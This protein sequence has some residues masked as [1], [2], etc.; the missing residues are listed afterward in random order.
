[1]TKSR[2]GSP[3][4]AGR[5]PDPPAV[6]FHLRPVVSAFAT[7]TA[8]LEGFDHVH[9]AVSESYRRMI[10]RDPIGHTFREIFAAPRNEEV[11]RLLDRVYETGKPGS[12]SAVPISLKE[13]TSGADAYFLDFVCNPVGEPSGSVAGVLIQVTDK[14]EEVWHERE[15]AFLSKASDVLASSL[16][17]SKTLS[18][19]ARLAVEGIADWCAVDELHPDGSIR[20]IAVAHPDPE[21]VEMAQAIGERYPPDPDAAHGIAH[22]LRTGESEMIPEIP[23]E[24]LAAVAQDEEHLRMIR[25]L[26]LRSYMAVPIV[27]RG[28][29]LGALALVRSDS[30]RPFGERA[31][32]L[33]EELAR[34]AAV[35]MD[36][37]RLFRDSEEARG[38]LQEQAK[39]LEESRSDLAATNRELAAQA[40][41]AEEARTEAVA[42]R[43]L[44]DAFFAGSAVAMGFYDRDLRHVRVN[45]A[46]A[47]MGG[48]SPEEL[49]GKTVGD[50]APDYAATVEPLL[51][52]VLET[53]QPLLNREITGPRPTDPTTTA[54]YLVSYFPVRVIADEA[55]GLG[56]VALDLTDLRNAEQRERIFSQ[57]LEES[58]NEIYLFDAESLRFVRVN[59]GARENLGYSMGELQALTPLDLKPEYT[60]EEFAE[61]IEPLRQGRHDMIHFET[62]HRRKDG[63]LYPVDVHL[64]LSRAAE[65]P[66]F[67]ALIVD[68]TERKDAEREVVEG[69]ERLRAVV[70]TAVDGIITIAERGNI[71]TVNPATEQIFGYTASE[72]IGRNVAMLMPEPYRSEHDGYLARYLATGERRIIGIGREV[73]GRRKDGTTFQLDLAISETTLEDRRF[74]TGIVRDVTERTRAAEELLAARDAAEQ[75]SQA[76]SKFLTVMSHELRT[77]LNAIIGFEDLLEAEVAGPLTD[78]QR[79][80]LVRIKAGATQLLDLI[81]QI[82]NLA[83]IES[84]MIDVERERV[85]LAKLTREAG[86]LVEALASKK[87]LAMQVS[88]PSSAIHVVTDPGKVRQILL[89]LLGNAVKFTEAGAVELSIAVRDGSVDISVIDTGP[90]ISEELQNRVFEPFFQADQSES[91]RH[92]G[93]GLGLAVSRELARLIGGELLVVSR[94]GE[95]SNFTLSIPAR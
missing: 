27:A 35:A 53:G 9:T 24:L 65:R 68:T 7:P 39:R 71:E 94:P 70:E 92:G 62:V 45:P 34:R 41:A 74:F 22:V 20:R 18:A 28:R 91:Q 25:E 80:H 52:Q 43:A 46:L 37:A 50:V 49:I 23:D 67:A 48:H 1:M 10:G 51:R 66:L 47:A 44:L 5:V 84:G 54:H 93:T 32:G 85:D 21:M 57:V 83:R 81:N 86:S 36:N 61:L 6:L 4:P 87:G 2:T 13:P 72:M 58:R 29:I 33:A 55:I 59:R 12:V 78:Q 95:G 17:Y 31:L 73:V 76:K 40:S 38:V 89:N 79:S 11:S 60:P 19:V 82:L 16:D 8:I 14:T 42:A 56:I 30:G 26:G 90:G 64:Q 88:V 75:A 77:P 3:F 15:S 63:S 69:R